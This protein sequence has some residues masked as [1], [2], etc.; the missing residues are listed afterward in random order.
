MLV[1]LKEVVWEQNKRE[2]VHLNCRMNQARTISHESLRWAESSTQGL[3]NINNEN[4]C[5]MNAE[6]RPHLSKVSVY[7]TKKCMLQKRLGKSSSKQKANSMFHKVSDLDLRYLCGKCSDHLVLSSV[8][9]I[10]SHNHYHLS[11][12]NSC[13]QKHTS[14]FNEPELSFFFKPDS[15]LKSGQ[16]AH[17][18][19]THLD[20][21]SPE[22]KPEHTHAHKKIRLPNSSVPKMSFY[23]P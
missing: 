16:V 10:T 3:T 15:N 22:F 5:R 2:Q 17:Q 4:R 11:S 1:S 7:R 23:V 19:I 6:Q 21:H 8:R 12:S 20:E 14:S 18:Q 9:C 13:T